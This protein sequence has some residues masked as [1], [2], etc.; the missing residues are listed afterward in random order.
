MGISFHVIDGAGYLASDKAQEDAD[1]EL[2]AL[3]DRFEEEAL[4]PAQYAADLKAI[5]ARHPGFIEGHLYLGLALAETGRTGAALASFMRAIAIGDA[6]LPQD[7]T[8]SLPWQDFRNRPF[9]RALHE[10]ALMELKRNRRRAAIRL[11]ERMMALDP[12]DGPGVRFLLGSQY[13]RVR[14]PVKA[15]FLLEAWADRYPPCAYDLGLLYFRENRF[16]DAATQLRRA[17]F[18]NVYIAEMLCGHPDPGPLAIWHGSSLERAEVARHYVDDGAKLWCDTCDGIAFLHWLYHH[19]RVMGERAAI[20]DCRDRLNWE[21]DVTTRQAILIQQ[22]KL[23]A[24]M[25]DSLSD[26]IIAMKETRDGRPVR[27]WWRL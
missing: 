9:L 25:D 15:R 10:A 8:S 3:L 22:D 16:R 2:N 4:S 12:D 23:L 24:A 6:A 11:M 18:A 20:L 19:P 17:F 5:V 7:D 26:E 1:G 27:P 21:H 14:E 13:L